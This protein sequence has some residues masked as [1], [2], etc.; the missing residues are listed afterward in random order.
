[1]TTRWYQTGQLA[2]ATSAKLESA[3]YSPYDARGFAYWSERE[4]WVGRDAVLVTIDDMETDP[5]HFRRWFDSVEPIDEIVIERGG[6]EGAFV[7]NLLVQA[8]ARPLSVREPDSP[9]RSGG[10]REIAIERKADRG[11]RLTPAARPR[12]GPKTPMR[13]CSPTRASSIRI[14]SPERIRP[15]RRLLGSFSVREPEP[16]R[17]MQMVGGNASKVVGIYQ[18][19]LRQF[20]DHFFPEGAFEPDGDRSSIE[21]LKSLGRSNFRIGEDPDGLGVLIDW[22]RSKYSF[23]ADQP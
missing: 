1:M 4:D 19:L 17:E 14:V 10:G 5:R 18:L 22:F 7:R 20:L 9:R 12:T 13:D 2:F 21:L 11:S 23:Q 6:T 3:C 16:T 8:S 15:C